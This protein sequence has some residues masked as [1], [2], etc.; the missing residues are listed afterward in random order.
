[1]TYIRLKDPDEPW[2]TLEECYR[3]YIKVQKEKTHATES[4]SEEIHI[5]GKGNCDSTQH[6]NQKPQNVQDQEIEGR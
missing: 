2:P 6:Q 4:R 3:N 5:G 1:M